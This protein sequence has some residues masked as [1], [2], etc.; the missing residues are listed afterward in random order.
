MLRLRRAGRDRV[1]SLVRE[2]RRARLR[3]WGSALRASM[4]P[5]QL[6]MT[7]R[8]RILIS[9]DDLAERGAGRLRDVLYHTA[10]RVP[11]YRRALG[12]AETGAL[13]SPDEARFSL[14]D[15]PILTKKLRRE[16]PM[17]ELIARETEG[18]PSYLVG[19]DQ[20]YIA[21]TSGSTGI[22]TSH[23]QTLGDD[24]FWESVAMMRAL[25]D[26]GVPPIGETYST[27]L[28]RRAQEG[29][30]GLHSSAREPV[31]YL[32]MPG[33]YVRWNFYELFQG[34]ARSIAEVPEERLAL[35]EAMLQ[36]SAGPAALLGAPSRMRGLAQYCRD[37]GH[38]VRPKA[39]LCTYEPLLSADR[40]FLSDTFAAPV[41]SV[42][43]MSDIGTVAW[44]CSGGRLHFDEDLSLPEILGQDDQPVP[45][46]TVGRVVITALSPRVMPLVRYD[47]GDLAA[48]AT[49]PCTCGRTGPSVEAIEGRQVVK[50]VAASGRRIEAY[51]VLRVFDSSGFADFQVVQDRPGDLR[52]VV[53]GRP[54]PADAMAR[55]ETALADLLGERFAIALDPSG[56][57][58]RTPAGKRNPAVQQ[59]SEVSA[60]AAS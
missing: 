7:A 42:Y 41:V 60:E 54:V 4:T 29:S 3:N 47:T 13:P 32:T 30:T 34:Q 56:A 38:A 5:R 6:L 50:F 1:A 39:V 9:R 11:H 2:L 17:D 55:V 8:A 51:L 33:P 40:S 22:P 37:R 59:W 48:F 15:F 45:A 49:T 43:S 36:A 19:D 24:L 16:I 31:D 58:V 57:F 20:F 44:E 25:R 14:A 21:R 23:L 27:G 46:G 26:W 53:A 12:L 52:V 18:G 35:Y 10:T 28:F